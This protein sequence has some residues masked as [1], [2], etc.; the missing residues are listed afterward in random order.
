M[1]QETCDKLLDYIERYLTTRL[2]RAVFCPMSTDDEDLDLALQHRIRNLH[3]VNSHLLDADIN[4]SIEGVREL[5]EL[6]I[7]G[8]FYN[9]TYKLYFISVYGQKKPRKY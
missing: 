2:Y 6:A 7:T 4:E 1:S 8:R 3:W 5:V 9:T